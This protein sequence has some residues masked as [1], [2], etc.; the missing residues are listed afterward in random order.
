MTTRRVANRIRDAYTLTE[1]EGVLEEY[2][3]SRVANDKIH[4]DASGFTY[5]PD[6]SVTS[7]VVAMSRDDQF[8][9][10]DRLLE[11][12]YLY[13]MNG[14]L[15]YGKFENEL[16]PKDAATQIQQLIN[17]EAIK[18]LD[19]LEDALPNIEGEHTDNLLYQAELAGEERAR[20]R[21]VTALQAEREHYTSKDGV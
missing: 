18:L 6:G 5:Y 16:S 19:R 14:G 9:P 15:G 13:G 17:E 2:V 8:T 10:L 12:V 1:A 3:A 21:T 20:N 11:R 4:T 7:P